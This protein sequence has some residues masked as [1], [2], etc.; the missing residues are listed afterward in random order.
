MIV[1]LSASTSVVYS[2]K[3]YDM[4]SH[5]DYRSIWS[6]YHICH[7]ERPKSY[8]VKTNMDKR[9]PPPLCDHPVHKEFLDTEE[10]FLQH[11]AQASEIYSHWILTWCSNHNVIRVVQKTTAFTVKYGLNIE[12]AVW[13]DITSGCGHGEVLKNEMIN[14]KWDRDTV[15]DKISFVWYLLVLTLKFSNFFVYFCNYNKT[16]LL[17]VF[18]AFKNHR[19]KFD[20]WKFSW[21]HPTFFSWFQTILVNDICPNFNWWKFINLKG[22]T[23]VV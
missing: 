12:C 5:I 7:K 18:M 4:L 13:L 23:N 3:L 22:G 9:P 2:N 8:V 15:R 11:L 14:I 19:Q 6:S 1:F 10:R 16:S 17:E 21:F 20:Q